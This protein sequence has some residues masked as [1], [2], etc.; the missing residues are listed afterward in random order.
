MIRI[1]REEFPP[2]EDRTG[3]E[4]TG[5]FVLL[6]SLINSLIRDQWLTFGVATLGVAAMLIVAFRSLRYAVVALVP[7]ALPILLV[8][9]GLGAVS[10]SLFASMP[11]LVTLAQQK[12]WM[13]AGSAGLL[14]LTAW[15][16]YRPGRACP[17]D[18]DLAEWCENVRRWNIRFY[19]ASVG[20][21]V[22]GFGAAYLALPIYSWLARLQ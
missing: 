13:F 21:W 16:L 2:E 17:A 10:G 22:A 14:A 12:G 4:V 5:F 20:I 8:S 18:P 19:R 7:N 15:I 1:S 11:F 6:A 9:L 3:A